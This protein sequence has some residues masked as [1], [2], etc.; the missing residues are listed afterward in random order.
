V[1]IV[2]ACT[3][4]K[5][6][7]TSDE[8]A[9][10]RARCP[11]CG[12]ELIVPS[13]GAGAGAGLGPGFGD[14][15]GDFAPGPELGSPGTSG[16]AIASLVLGLGSILCLLNI[17]V[18]I[19]AVILGVL[20][21]R[22]ID[23]KPGTLK[24]KG[25]ATA[26]IVLGGIGSTFFPVIAVLVALLLPAVQAAREA[27]RRAQCV[28][29]LKQM[30]LAMHNYNSTYD[31]F[32]PPA[33]YDADGKPL[34][35]WRVLLLPYLEQ[36]EL[37]QQF[38]LDEPWDSPHNKPLL[39]KMPNVFHCPSLPQPSHENTI[40][41]VILGPG[42]LFDRPEGI[43]IR[44]VTD[45]TSNTLLVVETREPS[46]WSQPTGVHYQPGTPLEGLGSV[47][48]GGFNALMADGAVRFI[49]HAVPANILEALAT[50]NG[51]EVISADAY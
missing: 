33:I 49:K 11:A 39:A 37:Y 20:G 27:A 34:L 26:G 16:K 22:D 8:N 42:T 5:Q 41:E 10:R 32:P 28:N 48:P 40:Y 17:L 14:S 45:G 30:G 9:G 21:L 6:F 35:S 36:N 15:G 7:Q 23:R 25:M 51:G 12:R 3:C 44:E 4:G 29:N 18:G 43:P 19:P 50:R 47:H 31:V 38:K 2:V 46:P 13:A 1:P 24:G